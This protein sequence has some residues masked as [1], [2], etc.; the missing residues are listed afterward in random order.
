M[1]LHIII[2]IDN[3]NMTSSNNKDVSIANEVADNSIE[4]EVGSEGEVKNS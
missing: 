2:S 1:I 4:S 3:E